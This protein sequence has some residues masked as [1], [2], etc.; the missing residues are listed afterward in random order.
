MGPPR[1]RDDEKTER[2][3]DIPIP[4]A[5]LRVASWP[6]RIGK[7]RADGPALQ[8]LRE[9]YDIRRDHQDIYTKWDA[10]FLVRS[11]R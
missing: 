4:T 7:N 5:P 3:T 8:D 11:D 10:E 9:R 6:G 1:S 2:A